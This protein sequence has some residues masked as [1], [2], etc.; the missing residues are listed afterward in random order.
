M[1]FNGV[2]VSN[3]GN[4]GGHVDLE[5]PITGSSLTLVKES[6]STIK[7]SYAINATYNRTTQIAAFYRFIDNTPHWNATPSLSD[8]GS[9]YNGYHANITGFVSN[10]YDLQL[11]NESNSLAYTFLTPEK[12]VVQISHVAEQIKWKSPNILSNPESPSSVFPGGDFLLNIT[13]SMFGNVTFRVLNDA[14]VPILVNSTLQT[15]L[16]TV[17]WTV[18]PLL[19]AGLYTLEWVFF[20]DQIGRAHV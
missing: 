17:N 20:T 18:A 2:A 1:Q 5:I 6:L 7:Y 3:T 15:G 12:D 16:K 13:A 4:G 8:P 19:D 10:Y 14:Q 9:G 11:L